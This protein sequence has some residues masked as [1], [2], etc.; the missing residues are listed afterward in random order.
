MSLLIAFGI[1]GVVA[2]IVAVL[3]GFLDK[4]LPPEM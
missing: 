3:T 2:V 4:L 1:V